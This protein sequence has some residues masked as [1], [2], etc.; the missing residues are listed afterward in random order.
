MRHDDQGFVAVHM[1]H[2]RQHG[3]RAGQHMQH[4]L[5]DL[6]HV[7]AALAQVLVLHGVELLA[8]DLALRGQRPF[9]VVVPLGDQRQRLFGQQRVA[10][11]QAVN[12]EHGAQL[13]RGVGRQ[14]VGQQQQFLLRVGQRL[15]QAAAFGGDIFRRDAV[16]RHFQRRG[17]HDHGARWR[18]REP[19]PCRTDDG[20]QRQPGRTSPGT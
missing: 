3:G 17:A 13:A 10:Q 19:R 5:D 7:G 8:Q 4:A 18:N 6:A 20:W 14:G 12:V 1:A 2:V 16:M 9:G 15:G 11:Q